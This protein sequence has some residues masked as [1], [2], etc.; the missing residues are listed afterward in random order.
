[1]ISATEY[2][3]LRTEMPPIVRNFRQSSPSHWGWS[4]DICGDS[5]KDRRKARFGV[6]VVKNELLCNCFNCGWSGTFKTYLHYQHPDLAKRVSRN[7]FVV[8]APK[9]DS[10]NDQI[11]KSVDSEILLQIYYIMYEPK[12]KDWLNLLIR[13]KIQIQQPENQ[14]KLVSIHQKYHKG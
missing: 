10:Y 1:M 12:H 2:E 5:K 6:S 13:K 14:R 4:C 7:N 11:I 9:E 8:N 3:I